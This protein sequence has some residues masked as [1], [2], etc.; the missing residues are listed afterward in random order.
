MPCDGKRVLRL[1]A[2]R[3]AF[4]GLA[5]R[6]LFFLAGRESDSD[7]THVL[8][9]F[10]IMRTMAAVALLWRRRVVGGRRNSFFRMQAAHVGL[11]HV[12]EGAALPKGADPRRA[13]RSAG[14]GVLGFPRRR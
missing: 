5:G 2:A 9:A 7:F 8:H 6:R 14:A 12:D 1:R 10:R 13:R 11:A 4:R 3:W